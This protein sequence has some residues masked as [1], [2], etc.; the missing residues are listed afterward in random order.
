MSDQVQSNYHVLLVGIDAYSVKP[1]HGCVNDIDAIQRLLLSE[2]VAI[3]RDRIRRLASPHPRSP[4]DTNVDSKPATLANIRAALAEL[5]SVKVAK[6][7]HIFIYYSGH[8]SRVRIL[9]PDKKTF[10]RESLVPVDFNVLPNQCQLMLDF[11]LNQLLQAITERTSAVTVCLDCCHS[12]GATRDVERDGFAAR[13]IDSQS[14]PRLAE[15]LAVSPEIVRAES[16]GGFAGSVEECQVVAACLNH[17]EAKEF[18]GAD[19]VTNGLLT[20]ALVTSLSAVPGNNLRSVPWARIWQK[21]RADV[22]TRNPWQHLWMAG[23][24]ARNVIAGEP[25]ADDPGLAIEHTG[26]NSV[27]LSGEMATEV[28]WPSEDQNWC[29]TLV[30]ICLNGPGLPSDG[31]R[32]RRCPSDATPS[33]FRSIGVTTARRSASS[34]DQNWCRTLVPI[35]ARVEQIV[36]T[37]ALSGLFGASAISRENQIGIDFDRFLSPS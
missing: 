8:G 11:E 18:T 20:H 37:L 14:E 24:L 6:G 30:P 29:R 15:P 25:V 31:W 9:T 34:E 23:N 17:E 32:S 3:P 2:R 35:C 26:K 7:D 33:S 28:T 4:H 13:F 19:G 27:L 12:A 22:E 36:S 10:H 1:L 21:T 5:G 16:L